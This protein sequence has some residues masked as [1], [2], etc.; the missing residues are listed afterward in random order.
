MPQLS[1]AVL[2]LLGV[3]SIKGR[4][5]V[6]YYVFRNEL[7]RALTGLQQQPSRGIALPIAVSSI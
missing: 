7:H 2:D 4:A 6:V 1:C 5:R 3:A